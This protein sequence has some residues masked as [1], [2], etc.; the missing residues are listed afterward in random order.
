VAGDAVQDQAFEAGGDRLGGGD[1][2]VNAQLGQR[3]DD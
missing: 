3:R 1:R 2:I